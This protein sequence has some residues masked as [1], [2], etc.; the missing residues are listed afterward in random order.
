MLQ[1]RIEK[2]R[3]SPT[4]AAVAIIWKSGHSGS[5]PW[6]G[7][8]GPKDIRC[9][10]GPSVGSRENG[11]SDLDLSVFA[12]T[13]SSTALRFHQEVGKRFNGKPPIP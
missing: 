8:T 11:F 7:K 12:E 4:S 9:A 10:V 3:M 1:L 5:R 6:R 13:A 2:I